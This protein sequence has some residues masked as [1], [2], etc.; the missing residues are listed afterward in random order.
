MGGKFLNDFS[1]NTKQIHFP[2]FMHV[3]SYAESL[4]KMFKE[5]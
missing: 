5:F 2:K 1:E 4:L 3:Y